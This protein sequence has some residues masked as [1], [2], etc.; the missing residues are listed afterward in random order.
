MCNCLLLSVFRKKIANIWPRDS[1]RR[2]FGHEVWS[3][4]LDYSGYNNQGQIMGY[5][6]K[7]AN[8]YPYLLTE[9]ANIYPYKRVI[10]R[11]FI[12][13]KNWGLLPV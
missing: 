11:G 7:T 4:P 5:L 8:S 9:T 2:T 6:I 12:A 1:N 13:L 3:L 10:V